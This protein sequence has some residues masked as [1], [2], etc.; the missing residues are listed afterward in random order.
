MA[1]TKKRFLGKSFLPLQQHFATQNNVGTT[2]TCRTRGPC[3]QSSTP[4][5]CRRRAASPWGKPE[6]FL[7]EGLS[8]VAGRPTGAASRPVVTAAGQ[9]RAFGALLTAGIAGD[10]SRFGRGR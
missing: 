4:P 8:G 7:I 6:M 1:I 2:R 3:A 10:H 5:A 9:M